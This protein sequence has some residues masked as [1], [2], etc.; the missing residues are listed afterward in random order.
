M[1]RTVA[2]LLTILLLFLTVKSV[3]A[4]IYVQVKVNE[5]S[6]VNLN[7]EITNINST[8]YNQAKEKFNESTIIKAINASTG[9]LIENYQGNVEFN[10][11]TPSINVSYSFFDYIVKEEM[12]RE[13]NLR[14]LRVNT[15]WRHFN[16]NLTENYS[17][18]FAE[19]FTLS[20][21]EWNKTGNVYIYNSTS[22]FGR[23]VFEVIG[24]ETSI[25]SYVSGETFIFEAPFS[26]FDIFIGS[27]Y[28]IL[29]T[30]LLVVFVAFVYRKLRY[31]RAL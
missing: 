1:K 21:S 9:I 17:I 12:D 18:N 24:P 7:F 26:K 30:V 11:E 8:V 16:L 20:A 4:D 2:T 19:I 28:A 5:D 10:D 14:I 6:S 27:P 29:L 31:G 3:Q 15:A 23:A 25:N 13:K 22:N